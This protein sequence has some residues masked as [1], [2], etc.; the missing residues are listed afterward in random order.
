MKKV[1]VIEDEEML[2]D[3]IFQSLEAKGISVDIAVNGIDGIDKFKADS[4][5]V[6]ILDIYLPDMKGYEI[7]TALRE[8]RKDPIVIISSG[9]STCTEVD[10]I[11]EYKNISILEKPYRLKDLIE[12]F[13][14]IDY[15]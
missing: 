13:D 6:V 10:K 5:R 7:Y 8:I 3:I 1:L 12:L 14:S 11:I 4:D 2:Q 15:K 9:N